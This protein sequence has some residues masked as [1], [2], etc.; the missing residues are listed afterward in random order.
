MNLTVPGAVA[1][2]E[3]AFS[4]LRRDSPLGFAAFEERAKEVA[5]GCCAEAMGRLL[6]AR[7]L[8]RDGVPPE[9][10]SSAAHVLVEADGTYVR[11]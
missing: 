4:E 9:A 6:E 8:Y 10:D 3:S 5:L 1:A 2:L 7:D 11:I